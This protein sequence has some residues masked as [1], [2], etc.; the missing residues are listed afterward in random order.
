MSGYEPAVHIA[1]ELQKLGV[2]NAGVVE[3][4]SKYPHD[5][6]LKQL[7]YLPLRKARRPEAFIIQAVRNNYSPPKELYHAQNTPAS[8]SAAESL[9]EGSQ[10]PP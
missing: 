6:I 9:D 1:I 10:P 3:L 2:S 5:L 7:E 4:L 8:P